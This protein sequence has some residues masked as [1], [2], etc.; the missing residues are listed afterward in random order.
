VK[1]R[2]GF[3]MAIHAPHPSRAMDRSLEGF[4]V[5]VKREKRSVFF[6]FAEPGVLVAIQ[7]IGILCRLG[8]RGPEKKESKKREQ[9]PPCFAPALPLPTAHFI[10]H[11]F[12]VLQYLHIVCHS[13]L[14]PESSMFSVRLR[15]TA[16]AG[17]TIYFDLFMP[18]FYKF[19]ELQTLYSKLF[20]PH[21][22]F[23]IPHSNRSELITPNYMAFSTSSLRSKEAIDSSNPFSL[24]PSPSMVKQ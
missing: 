6:P 3:L 21:S 8:C 4:L 14:D 22:A 2:L 23:A 1:G 16:S 10:N 5:N 7:A 15:R 12:L 13:G 19:S 24:I 9:K 11:P 17:V 20:I 18:L